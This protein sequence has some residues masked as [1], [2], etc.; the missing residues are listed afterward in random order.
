MPTAGGRPTTAKAEATCA[1]LEATQLSTDLHLQAF[2]DPSTLLVL[3]GLA[4][5]QGSGRFFQGAA[6]VER[7]LLS[8]DVVAASVKGYSTGSGEV[9]C[10]LRTVKNGRLGLW[11][12]AGVM[13]KAVWDSIFRGF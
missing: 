9:G 6:S 2:G 13:V 10:R 12:V 1:K 11:A 4:V 3:P 8:K 5:L 7:K